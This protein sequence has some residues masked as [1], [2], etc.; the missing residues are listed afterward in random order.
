VHYKVIIILNDVHSAKMKDIYFNHKCHHIL[1]NGLLNTVRMCAY[2]F[3]LEQW[4][5]YGRK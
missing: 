2:I 3:P 4:T 5:L 1:K